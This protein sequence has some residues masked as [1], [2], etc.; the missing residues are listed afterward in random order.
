MWQPLAYTA[1]RPVDL[2]VPLPSTMVFPCSTSE[3]C[4]RLRYACL[5]VQFFSIEQ[6]HGLP[7]MSAHPLLARILRHDLCKEGSI[8]I[9]H[10]TSEAVMAETM[11][12]AVWHGK[13]D[14]RVETVPVP[15]APAP[16]WV[17]VKVDWCGICG[18]DLHEYLAGPIFRLFRV[19]RG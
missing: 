3:H 9:Q 17:Q 15:P 12:A 19:F 4:L 10:L 11:Q 1:S 18:S 7:G 13:K 8:R 16:G 2:S 14:I 5:H 6:G